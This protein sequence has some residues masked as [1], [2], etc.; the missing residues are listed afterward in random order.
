MTDKPVVRIKDIAEKSNVSPATVSLVL[1]NKGGVGEETRNRIIEIAQELGY[2]GP[3]VRNKE[4]GN[5]GTIC[6]LHITRHGHI[7]NR[8]HDVF[9]SDYIQGLSMEAHNSNYALHTVTFKSAMISEIILYISKTDADGFIILGTEMSREDISTFSSVSKPLVFLDAYYPYLDFNFADMNNTDIIFSA[10]SHF[11]SKGHKQIGMINGLPLT[12]NFQ[13]RE[14]AFR[15]IIKEQGLLHK[16][17][18]IVHIDSIF[19]EAYRDMLQ[20]LRNNKDLPSAFICGN[21]ILA[22]ASLKALQEFGLNVPRDISLT[23]IDNLP[24]TE[25]TTPPLTSFDV[26]KRELGSTTVQMLIKQI[27]NKD[28]TSNFKLLIS[29]KLI[30]RDS[31]SKKY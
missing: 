8:D 9:I 2:K 25:R 16:E 18:W 5:A 6:F 27:R 31:V 30:E 15:T 4:P 28:K 13:L 1:N 12:P 20:Y 21:D 19:D 22:A 14:S 7:L 23:G 17:D 3:A 10:V 11:R 26:S 24:L 29:G